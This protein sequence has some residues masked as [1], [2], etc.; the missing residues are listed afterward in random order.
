MGTGCA[1]SCRIS[2]GAGGGRYQHQSHVGEQRGLCQRT[3]KAQIC[4]RVQNSYKWNIIRTTTALS[5]GSVVWSPVFP[6][7]GSQGDD[8]IDQWMTLQLAHLIQPFDVRRAAV[9][10]YIKVL[11]FEHSTTLLF[12]QMNLYYCV[13][14]MARCLSRC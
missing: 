1:G 14:Q 2:T 3:P 11:F 5:L 9:E 6:S 7:E 8:L 12:S 13:F 4:N 10:K